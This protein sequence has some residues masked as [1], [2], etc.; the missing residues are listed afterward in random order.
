ML[1]CLLQ[2]FLDSKD[3][4]FKKRFRSLDLSIIAFRKAFV[5]KFVV[6][7]NIFFLYWCMLIQ[8]VNEYFSEACET[9]KVESHILLT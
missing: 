3:F 1:R 9:S 5:T 2:A 4:S 7:G 6:C 8:S